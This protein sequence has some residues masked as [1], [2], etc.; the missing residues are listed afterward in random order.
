MGDEL[1]PGGEIAGRCADFFLDLVGEGAEGGFTVLGTRGGEL[2]EEEEAE[3][4][5]DQAGAGDGD[6]DDAQFHERPLVWRR[7]IGRTG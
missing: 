7:R 3:A 1:R 5:N 4:A 6:E 2:R